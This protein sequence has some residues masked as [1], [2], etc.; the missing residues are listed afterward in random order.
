MKRFIKAARGRKPIEVNFP[1]D[2][3]PQ[4]AKY[5]P[6]YQ[7]VRLTELYR[8]RDVDGVSYWWSM[9]PDPDDEDQREVHGHSYGLKDLKWDID[10][11]LEDH[12]RLGIDY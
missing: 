10:A 7:Q 12:A 2:V 8:E 6:K 5:L 4:A 9:D 1:K 11:Y 3:D